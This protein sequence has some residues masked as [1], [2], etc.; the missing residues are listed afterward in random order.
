[1][2]RALLCVVLVGAACTEI[3]VP[4][5]KGISSFKVRI[6]GFFKDNVGIVTKLDV[7]APCAEQ[8][9]GGQKG[10]PDE[11]RGTLECPYAIA[12]GEIQLQISASAVDA[13]GQV[14]TEFNGPVSFRVVPGELTGDYNYRWAPA[15]AGNVTGLVKTIHQYGPVRAWA[16]HAPPKAMFADAGFGG[17]VELMPPA[18]EPW[19]YATG[20]SPV[21]YFEEPTLA[22]VQ[23]P[24]GLDN[25]SSP[26]IGEF[27]TIGK[28]PETGMKLLQ[29][30]SHDPAR[31]NQV[32]KMVVTGTDQSGFFVTDV[33]ACRLLEDQGV[34]PA[35][36]NEPCVNSRCEIS[37]RA[38]TTSAQCLRYGAGTYGHMYIYNYSFPEG[39]DTGDLLWTLS[40][41]VQEFTSTTQLTFPSWTIA[42]RVH[43]LPQ[44]QWN[45]YLD[46]VPI[47]EVN[48][49]LCGLDDAFNPFLTDALCGHNRRNLKM[50]ANESGLV[51]MRNVRFPTE[52]V[53]CDQN[54]DQS[55]PFFCE[56][57]DPGGTWIWSSCSFGE[58]EPPQEQV[59]RVCNHDCVVGLG[60]H[61]GQVCTEEST[62]IGFGQ[63][64]VELTPPGLPGTRADS[65]L[66]NRYIEL[67]I[68]LGA[69]TTHTMML[70]AL[71]PVAL[72]C[73]FPA[74][75]RFG[76][77]TGVT[78]ADPVIQSGQ[79]VRY[80]LAPG[81]TKVAVQAEG[82]PGLDARCSISVDPRVRMNLVTKD[83]VPDL[84][85]HCREDDPDAEAAANCRALH[86]ATFDVIGH[87]RQVQPARPRWVVL[88][89]DADDIC[90][91][92]GPGLSC[93]KPI[94]QCDSVSP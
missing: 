9:D 2:K 49:R 37:Q 75:Y 50:E 80:T 70:P 6:D 10:V 46:Q 54:S 94:K 47:V 58:V 62:F 52:F 22:K 65:S 64:V 87:L 61:A 91:R 16:E 42:E 86:A 36:P 30:C 53:N 38:C 21:V 8:W 82:A 41:S 17:T 13:K 83:A 71:A 31:N 66:K 11:V 88:P 69:P 19:T 72:V 33:T 1:M 90:C 92:P 40:G 43:L 27:L 39:L 15:D 48:G 26:L 51:R 81:E 68:S 55:V 45:K 56:T 7:V 28:R 74:H 29:S 32:V 3:Q 57:T 44:E 67:N 79:L 5:P 73:N 24:D 76:D 63:F 25:R 4:A 89:R 59:E 23:V 78:A 84:E 60:A 77:G 20:L 12:R 85:P 18:N 35:E 14:A 34:R 93:P